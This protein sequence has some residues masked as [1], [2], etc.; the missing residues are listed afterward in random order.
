MDRQSESGRKHV[1]ID[2][3]DPAA[4][5]GIG[6]VPVRAAGPASMRDGDNLEWD[7]VDQAIDESF[8]ASDPPSV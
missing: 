2:P 7:E 8:P 4:D 1:A 5:V 3:L 6:P